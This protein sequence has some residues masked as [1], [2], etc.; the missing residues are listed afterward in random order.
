MPRD[1]SADQSELLSE[2]RTR[3]EAAAADIERL[4][5]ELTSREEWVDELESIIDV[6]LGLLDTPVVV[7]GDDRRIRAVSRGASQRLEGDVVVGKPLSSVVPDELFA[8][9]EARLEEAPTGPAAG[10]EPGERARQGAV[11]GSTPIDVERLPGG[12]AV[13]V[14]RGLAR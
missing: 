11:E 5:G 8:A 1:A 13:V 9:V 10:A 2:M 3:I 12:G 7:L 4:T 14:F 6:V